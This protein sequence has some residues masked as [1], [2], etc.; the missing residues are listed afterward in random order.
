[1]ESKVNPE[2]SKH[3]RSFF[4]QSR[5]LFGVFL[6]GIVLFLVTAYLVVL[7]QGALNPEYDIFLTFGA[8]LSGI[9][10]V[11]I[12]YR[13]SIGRVK[14]AR[15][16]ERLY[17]KMEGYRSGMVLRMILLDGAAFLQLISYVMNGNKLLL[18]V[19]LAIL[20]VF[21][22]YRPGLERFISEMELNDLEKEVLRDHYYAEDLE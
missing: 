9:A 17:E 2:V 5:I 10:L 1:M 8:P 16:A 21:M 3:V 11:I 12:A 19:C 6:A 14:T 15:Q 13:H 4:R 20:A 22:L 18:V 7:Y